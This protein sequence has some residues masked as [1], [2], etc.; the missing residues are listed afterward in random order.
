[1]KAVRQHERLLERI[2][3][4]SIQNDLKSLKARKQLHKH[5]DEQGWFDGDKDI[6]PLAVFDAFTKFLKRQ[7]FI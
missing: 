7:K 3:L 2:K 6:T 4:I 1:M 5:L